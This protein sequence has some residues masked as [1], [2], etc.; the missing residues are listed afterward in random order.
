MTTGTSVFQRRPHA[1]DRMQAAYDRTPPEYDRN[2]QPPYDRMQAACMQ[3]AF[4]YRMQ[5]TC[6]PSVA[7]AVVYKIRSTA[8]PSY[9]NILFSEYSP[10]RQ[11]RFSNMRLL[12]TTT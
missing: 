2:M 11:L 4:Y 7:P 6:V 9:L 10:T 8:R 5:A 1:Y 3:A 12:P